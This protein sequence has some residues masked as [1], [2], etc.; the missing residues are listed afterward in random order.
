MNNKLKELNF[1]A[2][3]A[4][5]T[6]ISEYSYKSYLDNN[7]KHP[8]IKKMCTLCEEEG[9]NICPSDKNFSLR[10]MGH[11]AL[12]DDILI[13]TGQQNT[14]ISNWKNEGIIFVLEN[15]GPCF[16]NRIYTKAEYNGYIKYPTHEWYFVNQKNPQKCQ[17]EKYFQGR[18]YGE[19]FCSVLFTFGLK[20][21]Y[22]TDL[23]K[24]G[25]NDSHENFKNIPE[26]NPKCVE[27][28]LEHYFYREIEIV[29]PKV[30]FC[31]GKNTYNVIIEMIEKIESLVKDKILV[32]LLPH[33]NAHYSNSQF[34][35]RYYT[36]II[37]G[38]YES[39]IISDEE[40]NDF[41]K[42]AIISDGDQVGNKLEEVRQFLVENGLD[43][44]KIH[45]NGTGSKSKN[46]ISF[47][48]QN[49]NG[50]LRFHWGNGGNTKYSLEW[51]NQK[52][53]EILNIYPDL[54]LEQ[55]EKKENW[56][57]LFIPVFQNNY[58]DSILDIITKTR[59]IMGY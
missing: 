25:M 18:K 34:Q 59:K 10:A 13:A 8:S 46:G 4:L 39:E 56:F 29:N 58:K 51:F 15:P 52:K 49:T 17:Y 11:G 30:I 28:C 45:N 20:N 14:D 19:F 21:L 50:G 6:N 3:L 7:K 27:N 32:K 9:V 40:K 48:I 16:K 54:Y 24:C 36:G 35:E 26:Y 23:V 41:L 12:A 43:M 33:P 44:H 2:L 42:K 5:D 57:R 53:N 47:S 38:L 37:H 31:L 22:I 1:N 55:G